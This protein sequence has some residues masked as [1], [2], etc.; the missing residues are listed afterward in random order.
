MAIKNPTKLRKRSSALIAL[1]VFLF[2]CS[3]FY[4]TT[5]DVIESKSELTEIKA[6][7][8]WIRVVK[9]RN[10]LSYDLKFREYLNEFKLSAEYSNQFDHKRLE[11][12]NK[13]ELKL[14]AAIRKSDA[15]KLNSDEKIEL[16]GLI[17]KG[18][19][20]LDTNDVIEKDAR[21]KKSSPIWFSV[22]T[23]LAIGI[24]IYRRYYHYADL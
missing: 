18:K 16:L 9:V 20:Y 5:S 6:T 14:K 2:G 10:S 8:D 15:N 1:A 19:P 17:F 24:Y 11:L 22:F 23:L 13:G 4:E 12:D 3:L 21:N 7:L